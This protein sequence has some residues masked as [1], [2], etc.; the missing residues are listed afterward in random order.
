MKKVILL[1]MLVGV[2]G[3]SSCCRIVDCCLE[4]PCAISLPCSE[5]KSN[6]SCCGAT[7]S[8]NPCEKSNNNNN[9]NGGKCYA[10]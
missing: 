1:A 9:C 2:T 5:K 6:G 4:D 8:C 10:K 3:L 7:P